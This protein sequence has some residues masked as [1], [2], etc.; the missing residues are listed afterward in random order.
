MEKRIIPA[1]QSEA[2][3]AQWWYDHREEIG[4]DMLAAVRE[5]R[6]SLS[7]PSKRLQR[8][9]ELAETKASQTVASSR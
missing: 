8:L 6:T 1:F 5:G 9:Q 2:E 7:S 4:A 3:E